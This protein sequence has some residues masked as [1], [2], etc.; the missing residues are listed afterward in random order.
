[1]VVNQLPFAQQKYN[2]DVLIHMSNRF[3]IPF[4]RMGAEG[5]EI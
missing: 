1:M 3:A 4:G 2:Y 5:N